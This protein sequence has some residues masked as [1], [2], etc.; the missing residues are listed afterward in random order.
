MCSTARS[1]W[2]RWP[3]LGR[4]LAPSA[5]AETF[6]PL[7]V[8]RLLRTAPPLTRATVSADRRDLPAEVCG[9]SASQESFPSPNPLE[10]DFARP[11][12][13]RE[14]AAS[15]GPESDASLAEYQPIAVVVVGRA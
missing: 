15:F 4:H 9:I 12:F 2:A 13:V 5:S 8:E 6:E 10:L 11:D 1:L 14:V 7:D 3:S